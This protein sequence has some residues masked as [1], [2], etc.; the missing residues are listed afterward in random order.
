M[1]S[2]TFRRCKIETNALKKKIIKKD[3]NVFLAESIINQPSFTM[4]GISGNNMGVYDFFKGKC[5]KCPSFIDI[6]PEYGQCGDIQTKYFIQ[7]EQCFRNFTP[8]SRVPFA[9]LSNFVIGRTCCCNTLIKACFEGDVLLEYTVAIGTDKYQ[10]MKHEMRF[11]F[12]QTSVPVNDQDWYFHFHS[13]QV[14]R[15]QFNASIIQEAL[16]PKRIEH[17]LSHGYTV[18][19]VCDV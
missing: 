3:Y 15:L 12:Y 14:D 13:S 2:K 10:Y 18:D 6:H 9:P 1:V 11:V 8:G 19:E 5:P 16:H 17:Y 7:D 4:T